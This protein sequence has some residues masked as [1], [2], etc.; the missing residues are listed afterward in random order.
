M[1]ILVHSHLNTEAFAL[2]SLGGRDGHSLAG[3][4]ECDL[5][6]PSTQKA[7]TDTSVERKGSMCKGL[8]TEGVPGGLSR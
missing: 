7:L 5:V 6:Y 4:R 2:L 3:M 1:S 8:K